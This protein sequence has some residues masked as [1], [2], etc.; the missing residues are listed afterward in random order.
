MT[1]QPSQTS[2][3][4]GDYNYFFKVIV[5]DDGTIS[6]SQESEIEKNIQEMSAVFETKIGQKVRARGTDETIKNVASVGAVILADKRIQSLSNQIAEKGGMVV[7][8][9]A[10]LFVNQMGVDITQIP[11][12]NKSK[13]LKILTCGF[14]SSKNNFFIW[15]KYE[16]NSARNSIYKSENYTPDIY[17]NDSKT[18][19]AYI[20]N[21]MDEI[22]NIDN[23]Q[24]DESEENQAVFKLDGAVVTAEFEEDATS[25][26]WFKRKWKGIKKAF[27]NPV[28]AVLISFVTI[29][30]V[31]ASIACVGN[32]GFCPVAIFG[33]QT[34]NC[35]TDI[36]ADD[37]NFI[38]KFS[39][40]Y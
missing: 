29:A 26:G 6:R 39:H 5:P 9:E 15:K 8:P 17:L 28:S 7:F 3:V 10:E 35:L 31:A 18:A 25:K 16:I 11:A 4:S 27:S 20:D 22:Q 1:S 23:V 38:C 32:A 19:Q 36:Y 13:N 12:N 30:T 33:F 2:Q 14:S 24:I 34:L 37:K 21:L 40:S